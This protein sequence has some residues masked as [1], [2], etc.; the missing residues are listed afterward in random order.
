VELKPRAAMRQADAVVV[1]RLVEVVPRG[2]YTSEFRYEVKRTYKGGRAMSPGNAISVLSVSMGSACGLPT[3][4]ERHYG[5]FLS[6]REDGWH[7]S[8]CASMAPRRLAA[9]LHTGGHA[10]P[11]SDCAS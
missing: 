3:E 10:G 1:G 6:R 7:G 5:L 2:E 11:G 8:S 4:L 9:A